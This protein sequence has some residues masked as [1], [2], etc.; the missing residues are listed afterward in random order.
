MQQIAQDLM[1]Q[2]FL[3]KSNR[4]SRVIGKDCLL[5]FT[6]AKVNVRSIGFGIGRG[7]ALGLKIGPGVVAKGFQVEYFLQVREYRD[8]VVAMRIPS[9]IGG[10]DIQDACFR[11]NVRIVHVRGELNFGM[12]INI[13]VFFRQP[14]FEFKNAIREGS[15]TDENNAI[16][17]P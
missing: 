5:A 2:A 6:D 17:M 14:D 15:S 9:G 12:S 10:F 8:E 13:I 11:I 1:R 3:G 16:E 4:A 7:Q